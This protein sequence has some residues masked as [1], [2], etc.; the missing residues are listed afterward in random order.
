M[1]QL[2]G[3]IG[4]RTIR[5]ANHILE[6]FAFTYRM[7]ATPRNR[8]KT[9]RALIS[10]VIIEQVYFTA[11]E[12]LPI[13]TPIA[14]IIGCMIIFQFSKISGQYDL[15]KT[16]VLL[17]VRELGPII[18]SLLVILRSASA[19]TIEIS[20]MNVFHEMDALEMA[21]IDPIRVVC[22]PRLV[23]I[24][25]AIVSL[26]IVFD[27]LSIIGGAMILG[28]ITD[29]KVDLLLHQIGQAITPADI[30]VG[31]IKA[32][33]FGIT[34]TVTCLYRGFDT[35]KQVTDIPLA[36]SRSAMECFLYC[37][38]INIFISIVFYL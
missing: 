33:L 3:Y 13:I 16:V 32:V 38:I 24:T 2:T 22:L 26:F 8:P 5:S 15:G 11:V 27:L 37:L 19:V 7:F 12:A 18:T 20:Y 21:G 34:I 31:L 23:G 28:G 36:T 10:R 4:R 1:I 30:A 14:L 9:G 17:I 35:Q 25:S 6:L 29:I